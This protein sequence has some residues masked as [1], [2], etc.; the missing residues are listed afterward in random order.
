MRIYIYIYIY[1]YIYKVNAMARASILATTI[2]KS[3]VPVVF[4]IRISK[5][6]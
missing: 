4:K 2:L 3:A 5:S 6:L 1:V